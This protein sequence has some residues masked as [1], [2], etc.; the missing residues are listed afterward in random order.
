MSDKAT[1]YDIAK[2]LNISAATVS[3]ALNDH[4]KTSIKTK[5]RVQETAL[6]LGYEQNK[7]ALALKSGR[8]NNIGVIVPR[9]DINF[10]GSIIR[11]IEDELY[12]KG[13]HIII[14]QT[15]DNEEKEIQNI[16]ALLNAQVDGIITSITK[17]TKSTTIFD[18]ILEKNTPLIFVDRKLN[19]K[20]ASSVTLN[21]FKGAYMA[22]QHLIEQGCKRI[23]HLTV[24]GHK[25]VEIYK[26]RLDGYTQALL[27]NNI[28]FDKN[29]IIETEN[30][31]EGGKKAGLKIMKFNESPDGIFSSS[32]F[33]LLGAIKEIKSHGVNIPE[34]IAVI[35][36]SNEPFTKFMENP[37]SSV[38]QCALDMG[39]LAARVFLEQI[40]APQLIKIEKNV[41]LAP[42][43]KI[44]QSSLK[45]VICN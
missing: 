45:K 21:D 30:D 11:G 33:M 6:E 35:G 29:L 23:L 5:I 7:L 41:V 9:I 4:P 40:N 38:D 39:K 3:R 8:S 24:L 13:Y 42:K 37:I 2:K 31:L 34:D 44:R 22:T 10:F 12:P 17:N 18:R 14:C 43:L 20:G 16:N 25:S 27:D 19:L 32:D 15:H 36:F 26:H 1:I 28:P